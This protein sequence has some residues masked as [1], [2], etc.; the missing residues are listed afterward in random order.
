MGDNRQKSMGTD[1]G[2]SE[3]AKGWN[4]ELEGVEGR[5]VT[6]QR[7]IGHDTL[8]FLVTYNAVCQSVPLLA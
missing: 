8:F 2:V 3:L 1:D 7:L 6:F 5:I 4:S